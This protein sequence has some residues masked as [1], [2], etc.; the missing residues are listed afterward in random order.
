MMSLVEEDL[1]VGVLD[2]G[3]I[4]AGVW[5]LGRQEWRLR[6]QRR[7]LGRNLPAGRPG[8]LP[9]ERRDGGRSVD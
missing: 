2:V 7:A 3:F 4:G 9:G 8:S 5:R 1:L 6:R